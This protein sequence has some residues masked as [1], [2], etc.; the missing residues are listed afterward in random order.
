V[1][2][3]LKD[4]GSDLWRKGGFLKDI[5]KR[6]S[7]RS[8]TFSKA[9]LAFPYCLLVSTTTLVDRMIIVNMWICLSDDERRIFQGIHKELYAEP[10]RSNILKSQQGSR[11]QLFDGMIPSRSRKV[12]VKETASNK[13]LKKDVPPQKASEPP[14]TNHQILDKHTRTA[15][16]QMQKK[17]RATMLRAKPT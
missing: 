5:F 12:A 3:T 7:G 9:F 16:R 17:A 8:N 10:M 1:P 4:L 6:P 11:K 14:K 15:E 2:S 13:A